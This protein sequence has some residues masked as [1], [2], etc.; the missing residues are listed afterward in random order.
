MAA[1][2]LVFLQRCFSSTARATFSAIRQSS[3]LSTTMATARSTTSPQ[4]GLQRGLRD[5]F[6]DEKGWY[7]NESM[8]PTGRGWLA[9]ELRQKSF[10]DLHKLWWICIKELNKLSSQREEARRLNLHYPHR[11]R[12]TEV[13]KTMK[14]VK[15][16]L[17]ERRIEWF[18][19]QAVLARESKAE[20]LRAEGLEPSEI[21][22]K[23]EEIFPVAV[24]NVGRNPEKIRGETFREERR[25]TVGRRSKS[26]KSSWQIV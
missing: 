4:L 20:E 1:R 9:A 11:D 26:K 22:K 25:Q 2:P 24:A 10:E 17:W 5:F 18:R 7:W 8:L 6:D 16:V 21:E 13:K 19:A 23:L 3:S 14:R 12:I 15:V